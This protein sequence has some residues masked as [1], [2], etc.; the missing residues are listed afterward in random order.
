MSLPVVDLFDPTDPDFTQ[1]Q[2]TPEFLLRVA[3]S[4][5][6]TF[7]G[8]HLAPNYSDTITTTV[9][10]KGIVPLP[11][12]HVTYVNE[13]V[14]DGRTIPPSDFFWSE[15]GWI[16]L[17]AHR[18]QRVKIIFEHGYDKVP[19]DVKAVAYELVKQGQ[20]TAPT[21]GNIASLSSPGGY[22]VSF[23]NTAGTEG[24]G[25]GL[26]DD[27]RSRLANYRVFGLA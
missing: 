24:T 12:R 18:G 2:P 5:I 21:G 4:T 10:S 7:L 13:V 6:R 27:Q 16:E 23:N 1:P 8:W 14:V 26:S 15:E 19:D 17:P 25:S 3:G 20:S 9:G 22:S 11:S